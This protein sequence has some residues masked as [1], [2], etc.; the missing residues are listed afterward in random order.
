MKCAKS[1]NRNSSRSSS[2]VVDRQRVVVAARD[3]EQPLGPHACPRCGRAARSSGTAPS[4]R[5]PQHGHGAGA[6]AHAVARQLHVDGRA[7]RRHLAGAERV[8][9]PRRPPRRPARS[10]PS[11]SRSPPGCPSPAPKNRDTI[12]CSPSSPAAV[13]ITPRASMRGTAARS[14]ARLRTTSAEAS[15]A[16]RSSGARP[17]ATGSRR[18]P[19]RVR[20][21]RRARSGCTGRSISICAAAALR[22]QPP[23]RPSR[24]AARRRSRRAPTARARSPACRGRRTSARRAGANQRRSRPRRKH[25]AP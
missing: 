19:R 10:A 20:A 21:P 12:A 24:T 4:H 11:R 7:A 3:L 23:A 6:Q 1:R 18:A 2:T 17:T 13:T 8:A 25:V 14:G 22:G 16:T 15:S 5:A 9:E